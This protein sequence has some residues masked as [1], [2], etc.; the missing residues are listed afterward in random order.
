M[1]RRHFLA[2]AAAFGASTSMLTSRLAAQGK[3]LKIGIMNDLSSVY[4]DYQGIGSKVAAELAVADF[5]AKLGVPVE[6]LTA[7]HQNKPDVGA[8]IARKWFD[9]D[10]VDIVMDLPNSAVALAVLAVA[11]EK[12]K[13]V[14]ASGAGA[15]VMTG[16][17][18]SKNFVHWTYDTYALGH[19]L[20]KAVT[21]EG[22][23]KWFFI[24]TDYAFGK[25]LEQ[26]CADAVKA[27][28]GVVLG[29]TR[30]P[31]NTSDF[32]SYILQ[33]QSSGADVIGLANAGGD[34]NNCLKQCGEFGVGK[35]QK[36]AALILNVTN[37]PAIGLANVQNVKTCLAFYWDE[38]DKARAFAKR[39][40]AAHPK[41]DAPN[42]MHAGMYSAT[43]HIIKTM[44]KIK[45]AADG[46]KFV[47]AMKAM[48]TEDD[49]FGKGSIREDGRHLHPMYLYETK[50]VA[51]SKS[52][53]DVFKRV[54]EISVQDA[55][56]PLKE[57]GCPFIKA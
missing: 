23:K 51:D 36:L 34:L 20:G 49:L 35:K 24:T 19:S 46:V 8:G 47:D 29:A 16:K 3:P 39:F 1:D 55:W 27:S 32:S 2:G 15:S 7:D 44:A 11:N 21:R 57:G 53:W 31:L 10:G 18:C 56:R 4:S 43:A 50:A 38:N 22:G 9:T 42:E 5:S 37:V 30:H 25:D 54:S 45:S 33:A 41:N 28:G 6:I 52:K 14:V 40:E 48:P 12:N 17:M 26:N 13:A